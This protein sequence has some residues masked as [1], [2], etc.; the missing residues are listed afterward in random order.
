M[1]TVQEAAQAKTPLGSDLAAGVRSISLDQEVEFKL[2]VRLV[3][4]V[5]GYVFW[6]RSDL[7]S[8]PTIRAVLSSS[9]LVKSTE[10]KEC[11]KARGSLHYATTV[12]QAE[13]STIGINRM[14]FTALQ[15]IQDFNFISPNV[16]YVATIGKDKI[17][18]AFSS[19]GSF[20]RQAD[21]YHYLGDAVYPT[22]ATQLIDTS[23]AFSA[24]QIV[25]NSLPAW[26][27]LNNLAPFYGFGN[28]IPVLPSFLVPQNEAPPYASVHIIP[29]TTRGLASAPTIDPTTSTHTQLCAE[30]ARITL[31]G[32]TNN[33]ALDF[34]DCVYQFSNDV[35]LF[36]I[37]NV[38]VVRDEKK[39]QSELQVIGM[40]K[41]VEFEVSYLQHR[42][43]TVARQVIKHCVPNIS[44]GGVPL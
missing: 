31:W 11:V 1:T 12:E 26:L 25:S 42:I 13:D 34:V 16:M 3:L 2:Y 6:V 4:P 8:V 30:T 35:S 40:K 18:F 14:V 9:Q 10:F 17:R 24:A 36:G 5:D 28:T 22:T 27:L 15:E 20:Y 43:N 39:T 41:V 38:P 23:T 7:V 37:M 21:L 29:E 44:I 33:Q 19:R 32:L